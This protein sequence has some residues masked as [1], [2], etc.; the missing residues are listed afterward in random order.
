[1]D[2]WMDG[3]KGVLME[4]LQPPQ[5]FQYPSGRALQWLWQLDEVT[6]PV[7]QLEGYNC[8]DQRAKPEP[9]VQVE[10]KLHHHTKGEAAGCPPRR[11][12]RGHVWWWLI[13]H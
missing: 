8:C 5:C 3:E 9:P 13:C 4:G 11:W 2:A 1:M 6:T 10:T 12:Q 7:A